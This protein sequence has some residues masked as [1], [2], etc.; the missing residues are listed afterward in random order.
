VDF[1]LDA[2]RIEYETAMVLYVLLLIGHRSP[3]AVNRSSLLVLRSSFMPTKKKT[4]CSRPGLPLR[5]AI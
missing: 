5:I 3:F 1:C 2:S 4:I